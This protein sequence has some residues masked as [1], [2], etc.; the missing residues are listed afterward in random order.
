LD[1]SFCSAASAETAPEPD[2]AI[3][4]V[5]MPARADAHGAVVLVDDE[6]APASLL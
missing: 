2:R 5:A 6:L 3:V 1:R 4:A